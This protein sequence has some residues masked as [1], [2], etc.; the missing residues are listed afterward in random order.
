[1]GALFLP[2]PV[3]EERMNLQLRRE[4]WEAILGHEWDDPLNQMSEIESDNGIALD[5]LVK[6]CAKEPPLLLFWRLALNKNGNVE[7]WLIDYQ[8]VQFMRATEGKT[9]AEAICRAIIEAAKAVKS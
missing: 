4:T 1:M 8:G 6:F 9:P 3:H 2:A 7:C 5:E